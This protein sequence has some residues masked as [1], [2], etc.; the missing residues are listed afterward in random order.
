V[1][2]QARAQAAVRE[3]LLAIGEDPDRDGLRD[4]PGRVA[5]AYAE[6]FAGLDQRP[7]DVLTT[8]FE[9]GHDEMVLVRD[10]DVYSTCEHHLVP[11]HG[12]AHVG[13]IPSTDGRVTGLSK[14]AR[15]VDVYARR[16]QVQER[17][18]TEIADALVKLL[19]PR[20][21]VV[22]VE[23]EH[24]CMAMRGIRRPGTRTITSAVRGQLLDPAS[25]A[26]AMSLIHGRR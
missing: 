6:V 22:V 11:F 26:E 3:L 20:G 18:T 16:P 4:T 15:L 1:I 7:E 19:D 10:I 12:V 25:R 23:C 5:R 13:Y 21:V 14:L 9:I 17:M 2:D 8:T 24:L